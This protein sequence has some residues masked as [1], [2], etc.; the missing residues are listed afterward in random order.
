MFS[1]TTRGGKRLSCTQVNITG[2]MKKS[3]SISTFSKLLDGAKRKKSS[4][5]RAHTETSQPV[6]KT[7]TTS[8]ELPTS[9]IWAFTHRTPLPP[10]TTSPYTTKGTCDFWVSGTSYKIRRVRHSDSVRNKTQKPG[11]FGICLE[12]YSANWETVHVD[13][14]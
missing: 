2:W 6:H 12:F 4:M 10:Q 5:L 8:S 7:W 3:H 13:L 14:L 1:C 11:F 9:K